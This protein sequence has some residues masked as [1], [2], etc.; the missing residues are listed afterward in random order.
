[1]RLRS[2]TTGEP[3]Q[4]RSIVIVLLQ[5]SPQVH[6][7][8]HLGVY[9]AAYGPVKPQRGEMF[10]TTSMG[11]YARLVTAPWA[12]MSTSDICGPRRFRTPIVHVEIRAWVG[13]RKFLETLNPDV[14]NLG[15]THTVKADAIDGTT[16][17]SG[18]VDTYNIRSKGGRKEKRSLFSCVTATLS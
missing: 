5:K 17:S 13:Q 11:C 16:R 6:L 1:M 9:V 15:L 10:L 8:R 2:N 14:L 3:L 4:S 7:H 18:G 12:Q